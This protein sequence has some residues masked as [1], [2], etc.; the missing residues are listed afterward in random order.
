M[1]CMHEYPLV[2]SIIKTASAHALKHM[3][4]RVSSI[5]LVVGDG[6][7][8]VPESI[9]MYFDILSKGTICEGAKILIKRVKPL[10]KC[11]GCGRE[12]ER[13]P[14]SFD[15]PDCG[16]LG[17]PTET[18]RELYVDEIEIIVDEGE[19]ERHEGNVTV[20]GHGGGSGGE[21]PAGRGDA[22][23]V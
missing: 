4:A 14:F 19:E 12:F 6:S 8:Y 2:Q 20:E 21:R 18:G 1:R 17:S 10:M 11:E 23:E 3:A 22:K 5:S 7:G 9:Q 16:N 15:C 13:S